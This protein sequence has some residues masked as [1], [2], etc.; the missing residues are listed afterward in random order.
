MPLEPQVWT[1]LPE[2]CVAPWVQGPAQ[3]PAV[4]VWEHAGPLLCQAPRS[5]HV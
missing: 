5:L 4:H 2:H 1:P 3:A